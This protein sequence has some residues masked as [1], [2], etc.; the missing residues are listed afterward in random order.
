MSEGVKEE[1]RRGKQTEKEMVLQPFF[2]FNFLSISEVGL[3]VF[4]IF[5][6]C[7]GLVMMVVV[8]VETVVVVTVVVVEMVVGEPLGWE[9]GNKSSWSS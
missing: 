6:S 3:S 9:V 2:K 7:E 1:G 8:V 4:F 5:C